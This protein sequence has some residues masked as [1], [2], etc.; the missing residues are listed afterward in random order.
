M[1]DHL[2][3][4]PLPDDVLTSLANPEV[5][6]QL[7]ES[8]QKTLIE[9]IANSKD[10]DGGIMGKL[11]GNK[12]E[13]AAMNIAFW[14]CMM[15]LLFCIMDICGSIKS[16]VNTYTDLVKNIIPIISLTLGYILGKGESK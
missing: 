1:S 4:A 13:N 3:K 11:F 6:N 7:S 15:L 5:L 9:G 14:L 8:N 12:K 16:G 10:K 2:D